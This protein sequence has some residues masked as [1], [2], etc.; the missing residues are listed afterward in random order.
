[1]TETEQTRDQLLLYAKQ[2]RFMAA[3]SPF[4]TDRQRFTKMAEE[5]ERRAAAMS[6]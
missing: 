2:T 5:F 4:E 6:D 1:M 3:K